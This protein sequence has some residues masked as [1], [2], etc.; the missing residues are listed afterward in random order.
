MPTPE[1]PLG[2]R[3]SLRRTYFSACSRWARFAQRSRENI[4]RRDPEGGA[5]LESWL[6]R[7]SDAHRDRVLH[8][9]RSVAEEWGRMN[10]PGPHPVIDG[11]LAATARVA[12]LTVATRNS[13]DFATTGVSFLDPFSAP[14]GD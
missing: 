11:L 4:R 7:V 2:S 8:I 14:D 10:V 6:G 9:D 1:S 3:P 12:G 13:E 5:A